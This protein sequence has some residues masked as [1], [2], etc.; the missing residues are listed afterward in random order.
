MMY[1]QWNVKPTVVLPFTLNKHIRKL[2][3]MS[4]IFANFKEESR[5]SINTSCIIAYKVS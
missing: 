5:R 4:L 2:I 3:N 1:I